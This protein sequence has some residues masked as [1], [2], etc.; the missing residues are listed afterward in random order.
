MV[1]FACHLSTKT[2]NLLDFGAGGEIR[3]HS[4]EITSRPLY[5]LSY[6]S[7]DVV[8]YSVQKR[9]IDN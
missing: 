1:P 3:T 9:N 2:A 8:L 5:Q 4:L 6:A 7:E